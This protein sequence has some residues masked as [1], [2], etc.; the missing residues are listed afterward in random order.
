[1]KIID[2]NIEYDS[3]KKGSAIILVSDNFKSPCLYNY[4]MLH[5]VNFI[6]HIF[7]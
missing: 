1:M 2:R 7:Y 4:I 3:Q 5:N 6:L